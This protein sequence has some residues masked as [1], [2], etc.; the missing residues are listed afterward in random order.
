MQCDVGPPAKWV[1]RSPAVLCNAASGQACV[2]GTGTCVTPGTIGSSTPTGTYYQYAIF[3]TSNSVF[4]GGYDVDGYDDLVYVNR[5]AAYLDVYRVTLLDT[6]GDGKLEPNQHPNNPQDQGPMEQRTLTFVKTY[7]NATDNAP[8]GTASQA[9]VYAAA[10]RIFSLGPTRN[11]DI[12]Q[13]VLATK[14]STVVA[15]SLASFALSQMGFG[16]QD[17]VWYGSAESNRRVY[18]F[19]ASSRVWVMEFNYP[20]L[21]G[22]HMDGLEVIVAPASGVQYVYVSD[23]TSDFVAQYR[24]AGT[25]WTQVNVFKYNDVTGSSVEGMGF[26]PLRHFWVAA[27]SYVYELGGGDLTPYLE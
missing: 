24:R 10:D 6:D 5:Q 26:G 8:M 12:T 19:C 11:G 17:G 27:G 20:S 2:E 18:S 22:S 3:S 1:P 23:M 21:A 13:Y 9:E 25:G 14:V 7:T 16:D 4:K 15:D